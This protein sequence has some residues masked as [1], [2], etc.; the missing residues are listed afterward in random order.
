MDFI[1]KLLATLGIARPKRSIYSQFEK[2]VVNLDRQAK[3]TGLKLEAANQCIT[4]LQKDEIA[5]AVDV[6]IKGL[7][8]TSVGGTLKKV[9]DAQ[10][11]GT[12]DSVL[13]A[14][15]RRNLFK[16]IA[17]AAEKVL[18]DL[19]DLMKKSGKAI[20]EGAEMVTERI[21]N[22]KENGLVIAVTVAEARKL[23]AKA[24]TCKENLEKMQSE[25]ATL[26]VKVEEMVN[27]A[28]SIPED[29]TGA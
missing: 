11:Q 14:I 24:K 18:D 21:P 17:R 20:E 4:H 13:K 27:K 25:G 26:K 19:P 23:V 8:L 10:A 29:A 2:S 7:R 28:D 6:A 15:P 22:C 1:I 3:D 5:Q 12:A 16:D 9:Q